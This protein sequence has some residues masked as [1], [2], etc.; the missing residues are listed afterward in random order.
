MPER[1]DPFGQTVYYER[2]ALGLETAKALP[3]DLTTYHNYDAA[4][5]VT[6]ILDLG[7]GGHAAESVLHV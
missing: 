2:D 7:P 3:N 5:Q 6:S 1:A 4:G